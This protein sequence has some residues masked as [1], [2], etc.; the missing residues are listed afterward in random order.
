MVENSDEA[1]PQSGLNQAGVVFEALAEGGITRFLALYQ[2]QA[3]S[4]IGPIRSVR[5]YYLQWA[6]GFD[7]SVAHVGGSPDAL[8]DIQTWGVKDL[9]QFYNGSSYHRI[10]SREAPHNV[11]TSIAD[12]NQLEENKG[13]TSASY[14][15]FPRKTASP[16]KTPTAT[17]VN[18]ALSSADYNVNYSYDSAT[19]SYNRSEGGSPQVDAN[20]GKQ[21]SPTV[22][23]AIVVP[24]SQGALDAS[25]AY[26]SDYNVIGSGTAYVFQDGLET[27]G[28]WSKSGNSNQITFSDSSG[29]TIKLNPGQTWITAITSSSG[30]SYSNN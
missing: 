9:D 27:T 20:N 19:N 12:L 11:Y 30:I 2:D 26:Y 23:I 7:A 29:Q 17:S 13:D 21:L 4:S 3:P 1:R 25:G 15:G 24:E 5:P 28:Q 16:S 8:G 14:S 18:L 10:S 6:L 22:V